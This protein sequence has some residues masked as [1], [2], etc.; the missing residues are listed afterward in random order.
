MENE[1]ET[2]GQ[3]YSKRIHTNDLLYIFAIILFMLSFFDLLGSLFNL[4]LSYAVFS[5]VFSYSNADR[6]YL[7]LLLNLAAQ[8]GGICGFLI[9]YRLRR[10]EPE[11][12]TVP[13]GQFSLTIYSLHAVNTA[14]AISFVLAVRYILETVF[15]LSTDSPYESIQPTV[16]LT[17][18]PLYL[19]LFFSVLVV[20]AP[21]FEELI[22]RRTLIPLLER[23]G[24]SQLWALIFSSLIFS[25]QH[26]PSDLLAGSP[27]FAIVHLF[28]TLSG[29]LLLGFLYL[30]TRNVFWPIILHSL[31]NGLSAAA[32]I[33]DVRYNELNELILVLLF[34]LWAMIAMFVGFALMFYFSYQ[35]LVH[36]RS[37]EKP[38]WIQIITDKNV[39]RAFL[40]KI[41]IFSLIF[42]LFMTGIPILFDGIAELYEP[43][44]VLALQT[45]FYV[46]L[47]GIL[48]IYILQKNQPLTTPNF[49]SPS[50]QEWKIPFS[51][52]V[53]KS[54]S[55]PPRENQQRCTNCGNIRFPN[56]HFCAFCGAE[57]RDE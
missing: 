25:L 6:P 43:I 40:S 26:T 33:A 49:V 28:V 4:S 44:T 16:S 51:K 24:M 36:R 55:Q 27:G 10:I 19:I 8:I 12:K 31:I 47:I 14:F 53:Q 20:G 41:T 2:Q 37:L 35:F 38:V 17:V 7:T 9:L 11:E 29:G 34:V 46:L 30:R 22:F 13:K 45:L 1:T 50:V 18:E 42:I 52:F 15:K 54:I 3:N 39:N 5:E 23:R 56:A 32:Q 21:V 57:I 48:G